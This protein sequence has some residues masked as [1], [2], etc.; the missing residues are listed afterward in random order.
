MKI[1]LDP[2]IKSINLSLLH[3]KSVVLPLN[4]LEALLELQLQ[5][6]VIVEL[7]SISTF[8][9]LTVHRQFCVEFGAKAVSDTVVRIPYWNWGCEVSPLVAVH[10]VFSLS[11]FLEHQVIKFGF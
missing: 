3:L 4:K 8:C 11:R 6:S 10:W 1:L 7:F 9:V 5:K 2:I